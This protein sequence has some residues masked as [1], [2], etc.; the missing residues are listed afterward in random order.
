MVWK[1]WC[2]LDSH[3]T[4]TEPEFAGSGVVAFVVF[5]AAEQRGAALVDEK[6]C[7]ALL[8]TKFQLANRP[9]RC[10]PKDPELDVA[11]GRKES[12]QASHGA[13]KEHRR[14]ESV[15]PKPLGKNT[16]AGGSTGSQG[17]WASR[18]TIADGQMRPMDKGGEGALRRIEQQANGMLVEQLGK[19]MKELSTSPT[20]TSH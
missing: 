18:P 4:G 8:D 16:G 3:L 2:L 14:E 5:E 13:G 15:L 9:M 17:E 1:E 6:V 19:Q 10:E 7:Y 20:L 12:G 11:L